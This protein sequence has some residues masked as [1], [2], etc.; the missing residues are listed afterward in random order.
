MDATTSGTPTIQYHNIPDQPITIVVATQLPTFQRQLRHCFGD[1][2][3]GEFPL[4]A[5]PSIVLHIL[6][7]CS[8]YPQD[9]AKLEASAVL[10]C[11]SPL[12]LLV[13]IT[14]SSTAGFISDHVF[15]RQH[16]P[17][18]RSQQTLLRISICPCQSLLHWT[19][20]RREPFLSQ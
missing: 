15:C 18:S 16:A 11:F 1:S 20:A 10:I 8:L 3:P 19:C 5:N 7:S 2:S 14:N 9:L 13:L 12:N 4:S 17:S 6:T